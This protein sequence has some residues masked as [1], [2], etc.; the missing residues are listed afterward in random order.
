MF[1]TFLAYL[2]IV[3]S[4]VTHCLYTFTYFIVI[5]RKLSYFAA[6]EGDRTYANDEYVEKKKF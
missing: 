4:P 2:V 6:R 3:S 1:R 5:F